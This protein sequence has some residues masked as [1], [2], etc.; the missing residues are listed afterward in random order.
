MLSAHQEGIPVV[1][2]KMPQVPEDQRCERRRQRLLQLVEQAHQG[3]WRRMRLTGVPNEVQ[4]LKLAQHITALT[5]LLQS[6][7]LKNEGEHVSGQ[8][9]VGQSKLTSIPWSHRLRRNS[10]KFA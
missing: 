1:D 3:A 4:L 6:M 7:G 10:L 5:G 9:S 8:E 2:V